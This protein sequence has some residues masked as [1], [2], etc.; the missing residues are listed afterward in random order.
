MNQVGSESFATKLQM[1]NFGYS[2]G[3]DSPSR[4]GYDERIFGITRV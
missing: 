1:D 2:V 4:R 3:K